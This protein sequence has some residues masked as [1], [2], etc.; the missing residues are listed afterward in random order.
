MREIRV[1]RVTTKAFDKN[2]RASDLLKTQ[3]AQLEHVV[4]VT[5][6][7]GAVTMSAK[8]VKTEGQAAKFIAEATRALNIVAR[9]VQVPAAAA[10]P[11]PAAPAAPAP[12]TRSPA[13]ATRG[14]SRTRSAKKA[15][16][17]RKSASAKGRRTR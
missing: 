6:G 1:P 14:G 10:T 7:A 16:P 12:A 8:R 5:K 17:S 4:E 3:V 15:R 11:V 2:R 13:R 9:P